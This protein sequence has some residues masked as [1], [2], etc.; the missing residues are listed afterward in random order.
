MCFGDSN[1]WGYAP[2]TGERY[3]EATRWTCVMAGLLGPEYR[4]IEEG[5]NGRTTA[6]DDPLGDYRNGASFIM[7]C[8]LTHQPLDLVIVMLGTNDTKTYFNANA[9]VIAKGLERVIKQIQQSACRNAQPPKILIAAP[10]AVGDGVSLNADMAEFDKGSA[11]KSLALPPHYARIA[12]ELH[13]DFIN[14]ADYAQPSI[15]DHIH[16]S[17]EGHLRLAHAFADKIGSIFS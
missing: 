17:P 11:K 6:F 15:Q 5:L 13:C 4:V 9:F 7:P 14:A 8:L 3:D 12:D 10:I 2:I 16:L 1:T